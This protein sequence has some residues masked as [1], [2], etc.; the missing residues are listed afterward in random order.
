ML[1]KPVAH[2][3]AAGLGILVQKGL[4]RNDEAGAAKTAL[5]SAV[6]HPGHLER[7]QVI[8]RADALDGGDL[9]RH[10]RPSSSW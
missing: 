5:R 9:R 3:L 7:M 1:L 6:N 10:P 8:R 2:V 4:G